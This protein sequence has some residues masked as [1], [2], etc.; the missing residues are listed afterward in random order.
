MSESRLLRDRFAAMDDALDVAASGS[1]ACADARL[2]MIFTLKSHP[3]SAQ[4]YYAAH[5]CQIDG[6]PVEGGNA[7]YVADD[8]TTLLCWNTGSAIPPDGAVCVAHGAGGRWTITY[9]G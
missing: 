2:V 9:N 5:P 8:R 6:V 7:S 4:A 1:R 3:T